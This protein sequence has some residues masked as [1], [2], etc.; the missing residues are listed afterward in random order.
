MLYY[1]L[2][3]WYLL[4]IALECELNSHTENITSGEL[5]HQF[6]EMDPTTPRGRTERVCGA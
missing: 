2:D 1:S 3:P 4:I 6:S 5:F